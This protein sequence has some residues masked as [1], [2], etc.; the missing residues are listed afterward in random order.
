MLGALNLVGSRKRIGALPELAE[1]GRNVRGTGRVSDKFGRTGGTVEQQ[2]P[3]GQQPFSCL[4]P[5]TA[6][7][8]QVS[9][10]LQ[11]RSPAAVRLALSLLPRLPRLGRLDS[12][13][14]DLLQQAS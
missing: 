14:L 2:R 10:S 4:Q 7:G 8:P 12:R 13:G 3:T 6:T 1:A 11:Q 9:R 5:Q